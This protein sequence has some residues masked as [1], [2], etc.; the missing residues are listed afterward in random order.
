MSV[1][2]IFGTK[3]SIKIAMTIIVLGVIIYIIG[4][5]IRNDDKMMIT[6]TGLSITGF[7]ILYGFLCIAYHA[8]SGFQNKPK[9]E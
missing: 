7:G 2:D 9:Y 4:T 8:A 1:K 5:I 3:N 6:T